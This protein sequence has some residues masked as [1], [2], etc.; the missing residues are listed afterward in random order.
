MRTSREATPTT[1]G[2]PAATNAETIVSREA[3]RR[4]GSG[5]R[6]TPR[7]ARVARTCAIFTAAPPDVAA[8]AMAAPA[9]APTTSSLVPQRRR[10][11]RLATGMAVTQA[12]PASAGVIDTVVVRGS[13]LERLL[14]A[15]L[16]CVSAAWAS[17]PAVAVDCAR[18]VAGAVATETGAI[19]A[20]GSV[21]PV[22]AGVAGA[23]AVVVEV[24][25][26]VGAGAV[27]VVV[28]VVGVTESPVAPKCRR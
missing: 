12:V 1:D 22:A 9:P 2:S 24:L 8:W 19:D 18:R 4:A 16:T 26:D 28:V 21:T 7:T 15:A 20:T 27:V 6:R 13:A 11:L 10:V 3:L 17:A 25:V 5:I 14:L 23:A